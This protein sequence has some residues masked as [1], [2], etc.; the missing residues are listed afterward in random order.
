MCLTGSRLTQESKAHRQT[1]FLCGF[2]AFSNRERATQ[3]KTATLCRWQHPE[4]STRPSRQAC[5]VAFLYKDRGD[6]A[7]SQYERFRSLIPCYATKVRLGMSDQHF[8]FLDLPPELR[9]EILGCLVKHGDT[10]TVNNDRVSKKRRYW[11]G[12]VARLEGK[13]WKPAKADPT[14]DILRTCVKMAWDGRASYWSANKFS[15]GR[16]ALL[17]W[18]IEECP[19]APSLIKS[20]VL[21]EGYNADLEEWP[22][23]LGFLENLPKLR[24]LEIFMLPGHVAEPQTFKDM[25]WG[26]NSLDMPHCLEHPLNDSLGSY[27][28][29][30]VL[31]MSIPE[32]TLDRL[33]SLTIHFNPTG[34]RNVHDVLQYAKHLHRGAWRVCPFETR[35]EDSGRWLPISCERESKARL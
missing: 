8:R 33:T 22:P 25:L 16:C 15:F 30:D 27:Y 13:K 14:P 19:K 21:G 9:I 35:A 1:N 2:P 31:L 34:G 6:H 18:F 5:N 4:P 3:A 28:A 7:K 29:R 11:K 32:E 24:E 10:I 20:I 17:Q 12:E 26:K 23:S